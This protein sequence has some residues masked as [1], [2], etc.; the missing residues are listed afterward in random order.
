[1]IVVYNENENPILEAGKNDHYQFSKTLDKE[2]HSRAAREKMPANWFL[3]PKNKK[4]P[5]VN[6]QTKKPDCRLIK[7]AMVRSGGGNRAHK[8]FPEIHKKAQAL[9]QK[10]CAKGKAESFDNYVNSIIKGEDIEMYTENYG[11]YLLETNLDLLSAETDCLILES[12]FDL[13]EL[14]STF[15]ESGVLVESL[16]EDVDSIL[17]ES[18]I[19][20]LEDD[21]LFESP[22]IDDDYLFESPDYIDLDIDLALLES[23]FDEF[24]EFLDSFSDL[25]NELLMESDFDLDLDLFL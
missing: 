22:F 24:D 6:P 3:D 19:S 18:D 1:M 11:S 10:Y 4:F 8:K 7:A 17:L 9:W 5:Y 15:A 2:I 20:S 12:E 23:E 13:P 21:I 25:G 16:L 14:K